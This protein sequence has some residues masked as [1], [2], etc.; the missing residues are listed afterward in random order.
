MP[1]VAGSPPTA[2]GARVARK[3]AVNEKTISTRRAATLTTVK[4]VCTADPGR[5]PSRLM[6]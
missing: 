4:K 2:A 6:P 5:A 1:E 3:A